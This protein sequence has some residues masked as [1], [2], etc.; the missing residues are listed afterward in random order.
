MH[1]TMEYRDQQAWKIVAGLYEC[2]I[3]EEILYIL[4]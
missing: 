1:S 4:T 3:S 2:T